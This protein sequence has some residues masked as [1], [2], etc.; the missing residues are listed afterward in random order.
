M[1]GQTGAGNPADKEEDENAWE[2]ISE[3]I[4]TD[5]EAHIHHDAIEV[6]ETAD[7]FTAPEMK[8]VFKA[9][10]ASVH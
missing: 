10:L 5:Q 6:P 7:P 9:T 1:T 2:D 3:M 4:S 8:P